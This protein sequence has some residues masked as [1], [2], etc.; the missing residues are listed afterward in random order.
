LPGH[1]R[2]DDRTDTGYQAERWQIERERGNAEP[3]T[4]DARDQTEDRPPISHRRT[5]GAS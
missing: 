3:Q 5:I 1:E 4:K 2:C